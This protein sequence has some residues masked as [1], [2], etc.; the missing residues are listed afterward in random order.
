M[1]RE[2][3]DRVELQEAYGRNADGHKLRTVTPH[4]LRHSFAMAAFDNGWDVYTLS[5]ALGH[6]DAETTTST[7]LRDDKEQKKRAFLERGP[8][9]DD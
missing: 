3:A 8:A 5:Q 6:A 4:V 1:V 7:Y 9:T 2:A